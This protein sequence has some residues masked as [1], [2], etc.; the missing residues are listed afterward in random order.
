M[1]KMSERSLTDLTEYLKALAHLHDSGHR[2]NT[3]IS[4]ALKQIEKEIGI[5]DE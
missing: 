5:D 2:C 1:K 3:E 4:R